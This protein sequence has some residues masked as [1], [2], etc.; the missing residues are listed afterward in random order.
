MSITFRP[1]QRDDLPLIEPWFDEG[2]RRWL[3]PPDEAWLRHVTGGSHSR[4]W[5]ASRDGCN[6]GI[7]QADWDEAAIAWVSLVVD[8]TRRR[9]GIGRSVLRAWLATIGREFVRIEGAIEAAN[10]AAL[11]CARHSGFAKASDEPDD[12][13]FLQVS[14]A[15]Q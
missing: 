2:T 14:F 12:E 8:P 3:T 6:V 9:R 13:G 7:V 15:P 5:I 4:A 1:L 10:V 11:A